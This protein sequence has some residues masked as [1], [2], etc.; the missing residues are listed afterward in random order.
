[1][2]SEREGE[3]KGGTYNTE[4]VNEDS[5]FL[6]LFSFDLLFVMFVGSKLVS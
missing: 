6:F 5:A 2:R 1:M 3:G 4:S